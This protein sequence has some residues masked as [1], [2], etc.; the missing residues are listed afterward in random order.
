MVVV[1]LFTDSLKRLCIMLNA[2]A[3]RGSGYASRGVP[4][5]A[6]FLS[7]NS[8]TEPDLPLYELVPLRL[9][10]RQRELTEDKIDP[11]ARY[12]S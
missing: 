6:L 10:K 12:P 7:Y 1:I 2:R 4:S 9:S 8:R 5:P 3:T 11:C